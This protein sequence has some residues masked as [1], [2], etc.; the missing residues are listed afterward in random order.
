[1]GENGYGFEFIQRLKAQNDIV[2]IISKYVRLEKKGRNYWG[3]CPFHHEKTP[4]FCINEYEQFYHCFGCG[5]SGDVITFL[6]KYENM[7]Y[8]EAVEFLAKN[9]G[10]EIPSFH[11]DEKYL[12]N[13]KI[14]EL[15]NLNFFV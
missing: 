8:H 10:M 11:N 15:I 12:Q 3:C 7:D 13:K 6:R 1:M 5:E 2:S 4:S 9:C 14:K